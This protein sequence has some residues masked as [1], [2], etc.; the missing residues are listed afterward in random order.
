MRIG[1]NHG[2]LS[3]RVMSFW[4]DSPR[5]MVESAIEFA[6]ICRKYDFHNFLFS[7][8]ASNPG[9]ARNEIPASLS[10]SSL[11]L[12]PSSSIFSLSFFFLPLPLSLYPV[13]VTVVVFV[14]VMVQAYRLLAAEQYKLGW[15]YPLHLGVTE[16]GEGEDG[17]MK[18]AIGI[19]SLLADG[20]GDTVR[21]SLTEDPEYELKP[22]QTLISI[23]EEFTGA[24]EL[25]LI[26]AP[27][28]IAPS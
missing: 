14:V 8:K 16:A 19:G 24:F 2:S 7:M 17:R 10:S 1:T 28:T 13:D 25:L 18:S 6:N 26:H 5:G 27:T 4:G 12:P 21:V 11:S 20:L 3:A 15:D 23:G 9:N 22:C